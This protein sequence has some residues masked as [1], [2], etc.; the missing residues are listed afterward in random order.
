MNKAWRRSRV[1]KRC[2]YW[3]ADTVDK[4]SIFS[5]SY[6]VFAL[7]YNC[8]CTQDYWWRILE[9]YCSSDYT[10]FMYLMIFFDHGRGNLLISH[11]D[12]GLLINKIPPTL[13]MHKFSAQFWF[14]MGFRYGRRQTAQYLR[15]GE[16]H[17]KL[18]PRHQWQI[19]FWP[20]S[21]E[22]RCFCPGN[23]RGDQRESRI[24]IKQKTC[25]VWRA[26]VGYQCR[27]VCLV[28]YT[29]DGIRLGTWLCWH[30][31]TI[32]VNLVSSIYSCR[33][34]RCMSHCN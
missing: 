5:N 34:S 22:L 18:R 26:D 17:G 29:R 32:I 10:L 31:I 13:L 16:S 28:Q 3:D 23:R 30:R 11:S 8:T 25:H 15:D 27:T 2:M 9:K 12:V 24:D 21:Q 14:Y 20:I 7:L 4:M 6:C 33:H 19:G 1:K